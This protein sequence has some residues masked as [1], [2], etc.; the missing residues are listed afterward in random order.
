M[1]G[2]SGSQKEKKLLCTLSFREEQMQHGAEQ[3]DVLF[4]SHR[5]HLL[6]HTSLEMVSR[7]LGPKL[8]KLLEGRKSRD[9]LGDGGETRRH[10]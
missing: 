6:F 5:I 9:L 1:V 4:I 8:L 7:D 2:G 3:A 10:C